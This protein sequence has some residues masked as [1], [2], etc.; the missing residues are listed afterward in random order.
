LTFWPSVVDNRD[1]RPGLLRVE[2]AGVRAGAGLTQTYFMRLQVWADHRCAHV[3]E[4]QEAG[5]LVQRFDGDLSVLPV[6][7]GLHFKIGRHRRALHAA[8]D[9][10]P[11]LAEQRRSDPS[12]R[13]LVIRIAR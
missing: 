6:L 1:V 5:V 3:E 10:R 9:L 13:P 7:G 2:W 4:I 8:D 11:E 12:R